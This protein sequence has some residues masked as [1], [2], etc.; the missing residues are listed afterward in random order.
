MY[1]TDIFANPDVPEGCVHAQFT[2]SN[3]TLENQQ[4]SAKVRIL[5]VGIGTNHNVPELPFL[6]NQNY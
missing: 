6:H 2:V 5:P 1:I 4:L 3:T